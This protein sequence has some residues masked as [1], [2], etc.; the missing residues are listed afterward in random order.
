MQIKQYTDRLKYKSLPADFNHQDGVKYNSSYEYTKT[1][2]NYHFDKWKEETEG[3]WFNRLGRFVGDWS[4]EVEQIIEKSK[5]LGWDESTKQGLRP[6]F[7]NGQTPMAAQEEYD[8]KQHGL[9][10]VDQTQLVVEKF[11]S[12]FDFVQK[13]VNYWC[14]EKPSYRVHVQWPGQAFGMHIDKLW[15]R[16]PEDPG[17]IVRICINLADFEPGQIMCYGNATYTQWRAG[18]IHIFDTLN[19]PHGTMNLS[20]SPRPNL[21]ITGLRTKETDEKLEL[22]SPTAEYNIC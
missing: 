7:A 15:H 22:A 19:V 2:S 8:R 18:D 17:R 3:V 21:V 13:M 12:Q 1:F 10:E 9:A 6:G 11:L 20:T 4:K 16:C 5:E 14:L